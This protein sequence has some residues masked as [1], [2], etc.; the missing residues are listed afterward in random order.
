MQIRN[1]MH[2]YG[3]ISI[4]I[5]WLM[6]ICILGMFGLGLYMVDLTYLD[7]WYK[8][9]PYAHIS[10]GV[11]L[12]ILLLA[13]FIWRLS[14]PVPKI[15]GNNIE[16]TVG[17]MVHRLHYVFMFFLMLSGYLIVTADGRGI[18]VFS[19]FDMPALFPAEK[20]REAWA[21]NI[22]R[23]LAWGFMGFIALHAAAALKH[24]FIDKDRTL[25][26]MLG[27][28]KGEKDE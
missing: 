11:I 17:L 8:Q 9:A 14:N 26:R 22:H 15:Y 1:S 20:G 24:H 21:G 19:W 27:I 16:K 5:H 3:W 13:R 7:S 18:D 10:T 25:L 2:A 12:F 28:Q 23:Y 6:A 4:I